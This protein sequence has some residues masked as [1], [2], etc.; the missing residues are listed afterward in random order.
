M[1]NKSTFLFARPSFIEGVARVLDL[2]STL[3][4]YNESKTANEADSRAIQKDWEAIGEDVA[5]AAREYE[6]R[7]QANK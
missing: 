1:S 6:R 7:E 4:V 3:Q 2:G 5:G